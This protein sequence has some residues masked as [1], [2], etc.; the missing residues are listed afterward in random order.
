MRL[1]TSDHFVRH[2]RISRWESDPAKCSHGLSLLFIVFALATLF[3][4]NCPP[5]STE[6]EQYYLLSRAALRIASPLYHTTLWSIHSLVSCTPFQS[7]ITTTAFAAPNVILSRAERLWIFTS[8]VKSGLDEHRFG[9][10]IGSQCTWFSLNES[11]RE[12]SYCSVGRITWA[13]LLFHAHN[14]VDIWTG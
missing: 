14:G 7:V 8:A 13:A 12:M 1:Q 10:Q 6:A 9:C 3:D 2:S 11:Y 5:C 4:P